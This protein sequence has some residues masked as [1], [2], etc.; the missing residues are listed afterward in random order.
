MHSSLS[1]LTKVS[2]FLLED[3]YLLRF[4]YMFYM[5][6]ERWKTYSSRLNYDRKFLYF[7]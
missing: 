6:L 4:I 7:Y 5:V 2:I 1:Y 3:N